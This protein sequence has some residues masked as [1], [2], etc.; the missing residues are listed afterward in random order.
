MREPSLS[1]AFRLWHKVLL[2]HRSPDDSE[3]SQRW[4]SRIRHSLVLPQLPLITRPEIPPS[5]DFFPI[6]LIYGCCPFPYHLGIGSA[7]RLS[8]G[9]WWRS[10][11][12]GAPFLFPERLLLLTCSTAS[13][14]SGVPSRAHLPPGSAG[15]SWEKAK[16]RNV[17]S[18]AYCWAGTQLTAS[19]SHPP[20][21]LLKMY[22]RKYCSL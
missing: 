13:V 2:S 6:C 5:L 21:A 8:T 14:P 11:W 15:A 19:V 20:A 12:P 18:S 17:R 10:G 16:S 9:L 4:W 3:T 1:G 7:N 22:F